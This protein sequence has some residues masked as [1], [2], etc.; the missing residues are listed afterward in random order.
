MTPREQNS[1]AQATLS[2]QQVDAKDAPEPRKLTP[3]QA[4]ALRHVSDNSG[5]LYGSTRDFPTG[6]CRRDV[7]DR[8]WFG[9]LLIPPRLTESHTWEISEAGRAALALYDGAPSRPL[10]AGPDANGLNPNPVAVEGAVK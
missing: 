3:G 8:L 6:I 5:R 9:G 1:S 7:R 4:R 2:G 10:S